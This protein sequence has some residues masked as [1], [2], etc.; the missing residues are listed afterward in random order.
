MKILICGGSKSGK[1][2]FAERIALRLPSPHYYVATMIATDEEDRDRIRRHKAGA[3]AFP[4][5]RWNRDGIS[6]EPSSR[7]IEKEL[8]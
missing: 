1:S 5:K 7:E 6:Q 8:F 4:F 3:A 2:A